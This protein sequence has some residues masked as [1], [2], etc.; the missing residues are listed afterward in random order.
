MLL[1]WTLTC[2]VALG[3]STLLLIAVGHRVRFSFRIAGTTLR[4]TPKDRLRTRSPT[5]P[6]PGPLSPSAID[7]PRRRN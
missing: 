6:R 3:L 2:L 5:W 4:A 7:G 1:A